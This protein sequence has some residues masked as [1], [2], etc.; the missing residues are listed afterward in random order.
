MITPGQR[1]AAVTAKEQAA[2]LKVVHEIAA[3]EP[4][5]SVRGYLYRIWSRQNVYL[6]GELCS[7]TA[8]PGQDQNEETIQRLL[9]DFRRR[10]LI[11]YESIIDGTRQ[12]I[13]AGRG[14]D[15][16]DQAR[17]SLDGAKQGLVDYYELAIWPPQA[18]YV[19]LLSEKEALTVI[20]E[21]VTS[22]YQV[23]LT[24]CKG[25]SSESLL[26]EVAK[27]A[28]FS[29]L[30]TTFLILT[31]HDRAG[32]NMAES[33]EKVIAGNGQEKYPGLVKIAC[34]EH[35]LEAPPL[36]FVR[37][38]L[39]AEQVERYRV[40][41]REPKPSEHSGM[42]NFIANPAEID[43]LRSAQIEEIVRQGIEAQLDMDILAATRER[44]AR[45]ITILREELLG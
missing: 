44:E 12:T 11:S 16:I 29:G 22:A 15:N 41:T 43:A 31:D 2:L 26:Y 28:R 25:F 14:W 1:R 40:M 34:R 18:K 35:R 21:R 6:H 13:H 37:I 38:G 32:Y 3:E 5:L 4:K 19:A 17:R 27:D 10:G 36:E 42:K 24:S 45:D 8:K 7:K 30:P 39:N 23:D 33:V 20:V 9:L